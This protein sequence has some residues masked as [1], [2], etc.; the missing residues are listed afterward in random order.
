MS[1]K[2]YVRPTLGNQTVQIFVF[3][4]LNPK[5]PFANIV[6][7]LVVDHE[8]AIGMFESGVSGKDRIVR[9]HNRSRNLWGRVHTKLQ[10]TFLAVIDREALH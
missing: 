7:G 2:I 6:D 3:R 4:S 8:T 10:F 1:S 9:L 5:T